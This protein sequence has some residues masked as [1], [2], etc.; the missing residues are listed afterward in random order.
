[1]NQL[2]RRG[3]I[4]GL[5]LLALAPQVL[6]AGPALAA[7]PDIDGLLAYAVLDPVS[8]QVLAQRQA[9]LPLPPASTL[10]SVTALYA[11]EKLGDRPQAVE[12][13]RKAMELFEIAKHPSAE[14]VRWQLVKW[15]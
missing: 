3:F 14:T 2:S 11:L 12:Q 4:A 5:G 8:G 10:K 9:D 15:Q 7:D 6:R 13:A 1:M